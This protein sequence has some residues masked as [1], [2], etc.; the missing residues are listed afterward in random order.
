MSLVLLAIFLW[1]T[2]TSRLI[3]F[4]LELDYCACAMRSHVHT[5]SE[6]A[7]HEHM[8]FLESHVLNRA[9]PTL[10]I[11]KIRNGSTRAPYS[12]SVPP[13]CALWAAERTVPQA[14]GDLWRSLPR[15]PRGG[16]FGAGRSAIF[17]PLHRE[18]TDWPRYDNMIMYAESIS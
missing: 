10:A 17:D 5:E 1:T 2:T 6:I 4:H 15:F 7:A 14:Q 13:S 11:R 8:R 18:R 9:T 3:P 16:I 12:S